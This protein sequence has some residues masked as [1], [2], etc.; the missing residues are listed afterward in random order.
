MSAQPEAG[1][2]RTPL[3]I[4]HRGASDEEPEHTLAAYIRAINQGA[5]GVECDVRRTADGHLVCVHDRRINRT[6][7]GRGTVSTLELSQLERLDWASWKRHRRPEDVEAPDSD[8]QRGR[9]LTLRKLLDELVAQQRGLMTLIETKHPTR[10]GGLV[11]RQLV[12]VLRD[13]DLADGDR[14]GMPAVRVMSFSAVALQRMRQMAPGV[15]LVYLIEVGSPA[16]S[17]DGSLPRGVHTVGLDV[18][19]LRRSPKMVRAHQRRGHQVFVWTADEPEDIERCLEL[20]V[21][22]IITNRPRT[23]INRIS[24]R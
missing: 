13:Y 2:Q 7:N 16:L 22:V 23:A 3:V 8:P 14:P 10:Y 17:W 15:P 9:L 11:E 21:D 18:K 12:Q 19:F 6:S 5:D 4:A 1:T 20:G 24:V